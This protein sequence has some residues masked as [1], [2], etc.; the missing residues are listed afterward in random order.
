MGVTYF[1]RYRMELDL[2]RLDTPRTALPDGYALAPWDISLVSAH[3][4]VKYRS[5][6]LELDA[7]VFPCLGARDG[8]RRLMEEIA[9]R[10]GFLPESTWLLIYRGQ[11]GQHEFC[12]TVQGVRDERFGGIQNLGVVPEHR[13][14]GLGSRLMLEA[15]DG[16]RRV[17]LPRAYLEVTARNTGAI[18]LYERM[19]FRTACTVYKSAELSAV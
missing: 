9:R 1:K 10:D 15:L 4:E 3:A 19:G 13:G 6:Q 17:G 5:F 7:N 16:F 12:G 14:R 11:D 18:R 2:R 8:C